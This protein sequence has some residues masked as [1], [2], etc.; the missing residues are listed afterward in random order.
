MVTIRVTARDNV[1]VTAVYAYVGGY[2]K[3]PFTDLGRLWSLTFTV[4]PTSN[5]NLVHVNLVAVDA[6]DNGNVLPSFPI[7]TNCE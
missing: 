3:L 7:V 4:T 2:G 6:M 5:T 1:A